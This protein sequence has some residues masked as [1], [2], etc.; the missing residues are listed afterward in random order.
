MSTV[1][2]QLAAT[3]DVDRSRILTS[4]KYAAIPTRAR[5]VAPPRS[6]QHKS[7][8]FGGVVLIVIR[9]TLKMSR[10]PALLPRIDHL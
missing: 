10:D 7:K 5:T 8:Y 6:G 4:H 3:D 1:P 2:P 9:R